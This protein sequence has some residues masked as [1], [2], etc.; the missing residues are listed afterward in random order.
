MPLVKNPFIIK[1]EIKSKRL[2]HSIRI[3]QILSNSSVLAC[4]LGK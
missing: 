3:R 4:K 2:F 1:K